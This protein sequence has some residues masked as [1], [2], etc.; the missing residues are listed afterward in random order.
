MNTA[1]VTKMEY[2]GS[3][4]EF[5]LFRFVAVMSFDANSMIK[6]LLFVWKP[7]ARHSA[8]KTFKLYFL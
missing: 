7:K 3:N 4:P 5:I 2:D 8:H 1:E 6:D